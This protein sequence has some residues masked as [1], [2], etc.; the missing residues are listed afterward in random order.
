[1]ANPQTR[2]SS[3][4]V[5]MCKINQYDG[6]GGWAKIISR[7]I[8]VEN[9]SC[10]N[11][12]CRERGDKRSGEVYLFIAYEKIHTTRSCD[13]IPYPNP[14]LEKFFLSFDVRATLRSQLGILN[15]NM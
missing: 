15:L 8:D 6:V 4:P 5:K 13:V 2:T 14:F 9:I 10:R 1:M 12:A 3:T 7:G 11:V